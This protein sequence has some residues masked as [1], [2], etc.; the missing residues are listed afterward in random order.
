[1][2]IITP[3]ASNLPP[4]SMQWG[5]NVDQN[6][7]NID[8]NFATNFANITN[9]LQQLKSAVDLLSARIP[10]TQFI[11]APGFYAYSSST[12]EPGGGGSSYDPRLLWSLP[13]GKKSGSPGEAAED[14]MLIEL[15]KPGKII[16]DT[17]AN[18]LFGITSSTSTDGWSIISTFYS[19]NNGPW[20]PVAYQQFSS[21]EGVSAAYQF[22]ARL[23]ISSSDIISLEAGTHYVRTKWT[24]IN[25][26]AGFL[27]IEN[28]TMT[29][30]T[31]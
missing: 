24:A 17:Y 15:L 19:I 30:T 16:L 6:I 31:I 21:P 28:P 20:I 14:G 25:R 11:E 22:N 2:A 3:P 13:F 18:T 29:V 26:N 10:V 4:E 9:Q 5:R 7:L 23:S 27:E 8:N 1:M 12:S